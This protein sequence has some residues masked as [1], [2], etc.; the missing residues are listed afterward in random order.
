M[1][2]KA[3]QEKLDFLAL[4]RRSLGEGRRRVHVF[5]QIVGFE[6]RPPEPPNWFRLVRIRPL[7]DPV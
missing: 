5:L 4:S 3:I 2:I 6:K 1:I 7:G